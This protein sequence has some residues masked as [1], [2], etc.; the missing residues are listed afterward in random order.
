MPHLTTGYERAACSVHIMGKRRRHRS[1]RFRVLALQG[2]LY[3]DRI[4]E[5]ALVSRALSAQ[6]LSY[7]AQI[8]GNA[9]VSKRHT[10]IAF[11]P[12]ASAEAPF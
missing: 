3:E 10:G 5:I 4:D 1:G 11:L 12:T 7:S 8:T 6:D 9:R 2:G